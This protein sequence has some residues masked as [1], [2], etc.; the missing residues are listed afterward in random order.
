MV[1]LALVAA[2]GAGAAPV[3][4]TA[5][6]AHPSQHPATV[7]T[8]VSPLDTNGDLDPAYRIAYHHGDATCQSGSIYTGSA[9]RCFAPGA[10]AGLLDPCWVESDGAH[11]VCLSKPWS[12]KAVRLHVTAGWDNSA[13]FSTTHK[14]WGVQIHSIRCLQ[15]F[16]T[17]T[18][19]HGHTVT[20]HCNKDRLLAGGIDKSSPSWRVREY[21][22]VHKHGTTKYV[23]KGW[24]H[25]DTAWY[26]E[27]SA[28]G[29]SGTDQAGNP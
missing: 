4:L 13:G 12:H 6:S 22:R 2:A 27:P 24:Q 28:P 11:V 26:G 18:P 8:D 20:Y 15:S 19:V 1:A 17:V 16:A 5:A 21:R 3:A 23:A 7:K 25:I 29:G 14:P 9:Y 10:P